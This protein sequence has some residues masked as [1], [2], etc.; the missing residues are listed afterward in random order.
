MIYQIWVASSISPVLLRF[1]VFV[2][3]ADLRHAGDAVHDAMP[4]RSA[5]LREAGASLGD[6]WGSLGTTGQKGGKHGETIQ[7][8]M[9]MLGLPVKML[10]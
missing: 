3:E 9:K 7:K 10:V 6:R 2:H 4:R 1:Q 8:S 5:L